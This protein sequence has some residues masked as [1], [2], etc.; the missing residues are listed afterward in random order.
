[1]EK[2]EEKHEKGENS[3]SILVADIFLQLL[4]NLFNMFLCLG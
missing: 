3:N 2:H 1:M 4:N